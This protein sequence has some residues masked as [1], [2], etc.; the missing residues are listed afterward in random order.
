MIYAG[1]KKINEILDRRTK[2]HYLILLFLLVLKSILDGFGLGLIAPFIAAIGQPSLIFNNEIFKSVN[3]YLG[4]ETNQ[5][6][7]L[8]MSI[9]MI[10]P[11]IKQ[12]R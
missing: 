1:L 8:W 4:I 2:R 7:I 10:T 3:I 6:L 9:I 11:G 12:I 5:E